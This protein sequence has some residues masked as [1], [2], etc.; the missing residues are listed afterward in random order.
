MLEQIAILI[1]VFAAAGYVVYRIYAS[2]QKKKA[3]D[4]CELMKAATNNKKN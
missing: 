2:I 1:I 3:C 4:K